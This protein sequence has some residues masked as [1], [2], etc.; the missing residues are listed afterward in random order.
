M[1]ARSGKF[2]ENGR[3]DLAILLRCWTVLFPE[4]GYCQG[5]APVASV[6]LMHMPLRDAFY[7]F[8]QIC[9]R[10]LPKYYSVGLVRQREMG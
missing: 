7:C 3:E 8:V 10:Y 2:G 5:Q 1:F 9:V 4:E 6:L